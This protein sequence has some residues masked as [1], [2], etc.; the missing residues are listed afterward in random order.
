[1]RIP[2][3]TIL[4]AGPFSS[5]F[6]LERRQ[7]KF[8]RPSCTYFGS[9]LNQLSDGLNVHRYMNLYMQQDTKDKKDE[10]ES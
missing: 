2:N 7:H 3:V 4:I 10:E 1:L 9:L 5:H 8:S 6:K